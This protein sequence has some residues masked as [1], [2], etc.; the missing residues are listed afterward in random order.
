[1]ECWVGSLLPDSKVIWYYGFGGAGLGAGAAG[2]GPVV[3]LGAG[4]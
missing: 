1:M 3:F 4:T 2:A